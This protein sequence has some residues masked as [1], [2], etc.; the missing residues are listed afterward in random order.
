MAKLNLTHAWVAAAAAKGVAFPDVVDRQ[1]GLILRVNAQRVSWFFRSNASGQ[2]RRLSLGTWPELS[3]AN[4]RLLAGEAVSLIQRRA[5][6]P[7]ANWVAERR[8]QLGVDS[9][10]NLP[11]V[12]QAG[13]WTFAEARTAYLTQIENTRRPKTLSDYSQTLRHP[14]LRHLDDRLVSTITRRELAILIEAVHRSKR[15]AQA[16]H[17]QRILRAMWAFLEGDT[18]IDRSQVEPGAMVRL[19]APERSRT[20]AKKR[21]ERVPTLEQIALMIAYCRTG[22]F[23]HPVVALA[24]ETVCLTAQRRYSVVQSP[25]DTLLEDGGFVLWSVSFEHLKSGET[26]SRSRKGSRGV[27]I[28]EHELPLPP[29]AEATIRKSRTVAGDG[30]FLFP[31]VRAQKAGGEVTHLHESSLTHAFGDAPGVEFSP[32]DVRKTFTSFIDSQP[33]YSEADAARILDHSEGRSQTV[34]GVHYNR[35]LALQ[36]KYDLLAAWQNVLEPLVAD[37]I[38]RIDV[39]MIREKMARERAEKAKKAE[40]VT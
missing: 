4:A 13:H 31:Q 20:G 1:P 12:K 22:V 18:Q 9:A 17:F 32:H 7:D 33:D 40:A 2:T 15:E 3:I 14:D 26:R 24:A 5:G 35:N 16:E 28:L 23:Q 21:V 39:P 10:V 34:T 8:L 29:S 27:T 30:D 19:K 25:V 37:I 6:E 38:P 11:P 36:L